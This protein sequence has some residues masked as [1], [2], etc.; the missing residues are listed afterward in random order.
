ML[1]KMRCSRQRS[2][3]RV[4]CGGEVRCWRSSTRS[5]AAKVIHV[6]HLEICDGFSRTFCVGV[7]GEKERVADSLVDLQ[8]QSVERL[9]KCYQHDSLKLF[10]R[11]LKCRDYRPSQI[12]PCTFDCP[13][14]VLFWTCTFAM[15]FFSDCMSLLCIHHLPA[16]PSPQHAPSKSAKTPLHWLTCFPSTPQAPPQP[17]H[18]QAPPA[19]LLPLLLSKPLSPSTTMGCQKHCKVWCAL[20]CE[21]IKTLDDA[22]SPPRYPAPGRQQLTRARLPR[23]VST[24]HLHPK[25]LAGR[26]L[27][28]GPLLSECFL[29]APPPASPHLRPASLFGG[30]DEVELRPVVGS[31]PSPISFSAASFETAVEDDDTITDTLPPTRFRRWSWPLTAPDGDSVACEY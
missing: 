4:G 11:T 3:S 7:C 20:L 18:R 9:P 17:Y 25:P 30:R 31:L 24:A 14:A 2:C 13:S 27:P 6:L 8:Y 23:T 1:C 22:P 15:F 5:A 28:A 19:L 12:Y 21:D 26:L 29:T 16:S 10:E